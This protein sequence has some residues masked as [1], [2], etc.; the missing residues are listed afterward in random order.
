LVSCSKARIRT[1]YQSGNIAILAERT[2]KAEGS[3]VVLIEPKAVDVGLVGKECVYV[4]QR[5]TRPL[6]GKLRL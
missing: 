5:A 2:R 1:Q 4:S 3:S 6:P